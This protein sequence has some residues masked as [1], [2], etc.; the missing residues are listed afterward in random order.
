MS[1][2]RFTLKG[3]PR[4]PVAAGTTVRIQALLDGKPH[5]YR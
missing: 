5:P 3:F 2:N 4:D 1:N